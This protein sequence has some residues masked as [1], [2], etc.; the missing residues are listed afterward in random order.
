MP[1]RWQ[2]RSNADLT[3]SIERPS[4]AGA[5]QP[6]EQ[7]CERSVHL[8][9]ATQAIGPSR[10]TAVSWHTPSD[11]QLDADSG[12]RSDRSGSDHGNPLN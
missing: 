5:R 1:W 11:R 9:P 4:V 12:H 6:S 7:G 10:Q 3:G 2:S 8:T